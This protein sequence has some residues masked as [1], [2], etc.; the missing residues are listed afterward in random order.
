V[1]DVTVPKDDVQSADGADLPPRLQTDPAA[2]T[3]KEL[4]SILRLVP[5][6]VHAPMQVLLGSLIGVATILTVLMLMPAQDENGLRRQIDNLKGQNDR[7]RGELKLSGRKNKEYE[8]KLGGASSEQARMQATINALELSS[9][10]ARLRMK[11]IPLTLD[12]G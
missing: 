6:I 9:A 3:K 2:E 1:L 7:L 4:P 8:D 5:A 10:I 11:E 12:R